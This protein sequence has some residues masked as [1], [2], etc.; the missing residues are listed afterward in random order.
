MGR[1]GQGCSR[2]AVRAFFPI[3]CYIEHLTC[4]YTFHLV[5]I[6]IYKLPINK[7]PELPDKQRKPAP[8]LAL[9]EIQIRQKPAR[10]QPDFWQNCQAAKL[11]VASVKLLLIMSGSYVGHK[12]PAQWRDLLTN[13]VDQ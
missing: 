2:L 5:Y 10:Y 7:P 12:K 3:C 9:R 1:S 8:G 13:T 11:L 4:K 6:F